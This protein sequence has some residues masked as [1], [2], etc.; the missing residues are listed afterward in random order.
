MKLIK[1]IEERWSPRSYDSRP[2]NEE[3]LA[4][5]FEAARWLLPATMPRSGHI[6]IRLANIRK[7][8]PGSRSAS[9]EAIEPGRPMLRCYWFPADTR[10]SRGRMS[11]TGT[12]CT[13]WAPRTSRSPCKPPR[14]E[15]NCIRWPASTWNLRP[16]AGPRHG[17]I[18]PVTMMTLGYPGPADRLAEPFRTRETLPRERKEV[19]SFVHKLE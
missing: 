13:M 2:V 11:I 6:T 16:A 17:K 1:T 7:L 5:L 4:L 3:Q 10:I 12:G 9:P 14:W 15:C 8:M 18:E 19:K